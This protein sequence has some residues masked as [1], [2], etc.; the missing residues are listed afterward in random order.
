M[1]GRSRQVVAVLDRTAYA[2]AVRS[3]EREAAALGIS[4]APFFVID[5]TYG[6]SWAQSPEVL[7]EVLQRA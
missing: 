7:L 3:D 1:R 6:V 2:A 5:R 4:P